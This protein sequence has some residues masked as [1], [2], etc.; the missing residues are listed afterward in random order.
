M[1]E[2]MFSTLLNSYNQNNRFKLFPYFTVCFSI[3]P[4][5]LKVAC[6]GFQG[7]HKSILRHIDLDKYSFK[8]VF[9]YW[10]TDN[11]K[12]AA[13][14]N[15]YANEYL[16]KS[17]SGQMLIHFQSQF[18]A[19]QVNF[20]YNIDLPDSEKW[21]LETNHIL[22]SKFGNEKLPKFKVLVAADGGF[23][24]EDVNTLDFK[25]V[26]INEL[27]NDDFVEIDALISRSMER[28]KRDRHH[29][30]A[31]PGTGQDQLHQKSDLQVQGQGLHLYSKRFC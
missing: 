31:H 2:P 28:K 5:A 3:L 10:L 16:F 11:S 12:D 20:L 27:Y 6:R 25:S 29:S 30:A 26:D 8:P 21:I 23:Y 13:Q 9:K 17:K 14:S 24:T 18:K 22:R 19:I 4:T 15:D 1:D 7:N